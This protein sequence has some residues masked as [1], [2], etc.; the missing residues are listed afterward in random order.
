MENKFIENMILRREHVAEY[1]YDNA[2]LYNVEPLKAYM[3]GILN[4]RDRIVKDK[5]MLGKF[6]VKLCEIGI[7]TYI[8]SALSWFRVDPQSYRDYYAIAEPPKML[9]L[10]WE[11]EYKICN[12]GTADYEKRLSEIGT[13]Y[14]TD[15]KEYQTAKKTIDWLNRSEVI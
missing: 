3:V 7:P 12:D 9:Q 8:T 13:I 11:A 4:D 10:L 2:D 6:D 1:M 14:G 5:E 15:S